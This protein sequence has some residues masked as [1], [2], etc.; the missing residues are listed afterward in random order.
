VIADW[1]R[2]T[3]KLGAGLV[4]V[5]LAYIGFLPA[6]PKAELGCVRESQRRNP[7]V[8]EQRNAAECRGGLGCSQQDARGGQSAFDDPRHRTSDLLK[9][10]K[11][12]T[13][14]ALLDQKKK[15]A[16]LLTPPFPSL[17]LCAL[18]LLIDAS[19]QGRGLQ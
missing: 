3:A 13:T 10:R 18:L 6:H 7:S 8:Y 16:H 14:P 15:M 5:H 2:R 9:K 19:Q 12:P 17:T 11:W 4:E 1:R